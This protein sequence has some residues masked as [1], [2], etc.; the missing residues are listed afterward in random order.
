MAH[1][2][3]LAGKKVFRDFDGNMWERTEDGEA[4][5]WMGKYDAATKTLDASAEEPACEDE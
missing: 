4:G 2:W 3:V 1:E 5:A